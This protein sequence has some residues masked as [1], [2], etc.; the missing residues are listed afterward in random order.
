MN[1]SNAH[2]LSTWLLS[3]VLFRDW[4]PLIMHTTNPT[5]FYPPI[6]L[7]PSQFLPPLIFHNLSAV[8]RYNSTI[9]SN[10]ITN[11]TARRVTRRTSSIVFRNSSLSFLTSD[12]SAAFSVMANSGSRRGRESQHWL[13]MG[14][15]T[16]S[17]TDQVFTTLS[18]FMLSSSSSIP[19]DSLFFLSIWDSGLLCLDTRPV[20]VSLVG[21][22]SFLFHLCA[23]SS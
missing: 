23:L 12:I 3:D 16:L 13:V 20:F 19:F 17:A 22:S 4:S 5:P 9:A 6:E 2:P 21:Q 14:T 15:L 8:Q 10:G 1:T 11:V 7:Y 18:S